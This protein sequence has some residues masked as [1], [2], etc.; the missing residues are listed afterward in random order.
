MSGSQEGHALTIGDQQQVV[1]ITFPD[2]TEKS[3]R[4]RLSRSG[5]KPLSVRISPAEK[6]DVEGHALDSKSVSLNLQLEGDDTA[7]HAISLHFPTAEEADKFRRNLL[8]AGIL[9]GTI[10]VG[11]AGAIA[12][13]SQPA[14][15]APVDQSQTYERPGANAVSPVTG[16]NP[17]TG[18]PWRSGFQERA[19]GELTG[20]GDAAPP[21]LRHPAGSGPVAGVE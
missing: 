19:D 4:G 11:S 7:G 5:G 16:I 8:L 12:I 21:A 1:P 6:S 3:L 20:P 18:Q 13:T 14:T 9:A 15:S 17:A 2:Q 10:V